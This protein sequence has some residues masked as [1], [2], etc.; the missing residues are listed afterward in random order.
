[1]D[2]SYSDEFWDFYNSLSEHE[3]LKIL[4]CVFLLKRQTLLKESTALAQVENEKSKEILRL[5]E[6]LNAN[7]TTL[8]DIITKHLTF[9]QNPNFVKDLNKQRYGNHSLGQ[10]GEQKLQEILGY[11][12]IQFT[13]TSRM[14]GYGDLIIHHHTFN[15]NCVNQNIDIMVECKNVAQITMNSKLRDY[16]AQF[17][18]NLAV[19]YAE[20]R[21][22]AGILLFMRE[23]TQISPLTNRFMTHYLPDGEIVTILL[24]DRVGTMDKHNAAGYGELK[25]SIDLLGV[26]SNFLLT[27]EKEY[28]REFS[29]TKKVENAVRLIEQ[30]LKQ[31]INIKRCYNT[32]GTQLDELHK[33]IEKLQAELLCTE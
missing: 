28:S 5:Q 19:A 23:D 6:Q 3:T 12:G 20:R 2:N 27:K 31:F 17:K 32:L 33:N 24:L 30:Q 26:L 4:H 18:D 11:L 22:N 7:K 16:I 14:K 21:I 29:N 15:A 13:D 8:N 1:M 10:L 25:L 9:Y